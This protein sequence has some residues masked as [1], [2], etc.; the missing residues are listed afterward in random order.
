MGSKELQV[1]TTKAH[2]FSLDKRTKKDWKPLSA[3][4]AVPLIIYHNEETGVFRLIS[5]T[6]DQTVLINCTMDASMKFIRPSSK[7]C[8][9]L[10]TTARKTYGL[11]FSSSAEQTKFKEQFESVVE[12]LAAQG[13]QDKESEH[14]DGGGVADT[15]EKAALVNS[16]GRPE[17]PA[18]SPPVHSK[19]NSHDAMAAP[20]PASHDSKTTTPAGTAPVSPTTEEQPPLVLAAVT[21]IPDT[22]PTTAKQA[23]QDG[24]GNET[25]PAVTIASPAPIEN[26]QSFN[27]SSG[28]TDVPPSPTRKHHDNAPRRERPGSGSGRRTGGNLLTK[29]LSGGGSGR[30]VRDEGSEGETLPAGSTQSKLES[31]GDHGPRSVVSP[32]EINVKAGALY[33][34]ENNARDDSPQRTTQRRPS[35]SG[36]SAPDASDQLAQLKKENDQLKIALATSSSRANQWETELQKLKHNNV[37]LLTTLQESQ[38]NVDEWKKQ[39]TL[40]K[41]DNA[42][43]KHRLKEREL[44]THLVT[45]LQQEANEWEKTKRQLTEDLADTRT[46]LDKKEQ[47]CESLTNDLETMSMLAPKLQAANDRCK[48]L[49]SAK[50][51]LTEKLAEVQDQLRLARTASAIR[52]ER[53]TEQHRLLGGT[54]LEMNQ[55]HSQ[56]EQDLQ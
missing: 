42:S 55:L 10:D 2:I 22:G 49:G 54:L 26:A 33:R 19:Q 38:S 24:Y 11:G 43:M 46:R 9:F 5:F 21:A 16:S 28:N 40:Y 30:D 53:L 13:R 31:S 12:T 32:T 1:F 27:G 44:A 17:S 35:I 23:V 45:Q 7:F 20:V 41:D 37:R 29:L 48:E 34:R 47:E 3:N 39:L 8:Q 25:V 51:E 18:S 50:A 15:S 14:S 56:M 52:L 4:Q 6:G 36:P